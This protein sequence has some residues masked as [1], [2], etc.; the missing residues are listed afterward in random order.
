VIDE[1][2]RSKRGRKALPVGEKR[3]HTVSVRLADAELALL[4]G[5]RGRFRRGEWM[6]MAG[7]DRLPPSIPALNVKSYRELNRLAANINQIARAV[8]CGKQVDL[9]E[10]RQ[11]LG[12]LRHRL[13]GIVPDL[14]DDEPT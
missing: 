3:T 7:L 13:I 14:G 6:R 1:R 4:D 9:L 8:N 11:L 12:D 10:I 5:K 2:R